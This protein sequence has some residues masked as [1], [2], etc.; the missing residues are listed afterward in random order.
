MRVLP[1]LPRRPESDSPPGA[2]LYGAGLCPWAEKAQRGDGTVHL[3]GAGGAGE[4]RERT[5]DKDCVAVATF[6]AG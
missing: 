4:L 6:D 3:Y 1:V 2:G 5:A